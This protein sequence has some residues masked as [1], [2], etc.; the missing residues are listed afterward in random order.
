MNQPARHVLALA[1]ALAVA[2]FSSPALAHEACEAD[3]DCATGE[4]CH[5]EEC[6]VTCAEDA[7]CPEDQTC[8][9]EVCHHADEA[10]EEGCTAGGT[11]PGESLPLVALALLAV[12]L[13]RRKRSAR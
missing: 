13:A 1:V 11:P 3:T 5:E 4:V 9:E 8:S 10:E 7:D 2:A 12:P 6:A